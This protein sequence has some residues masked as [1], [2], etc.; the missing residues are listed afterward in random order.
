MG[1]WAR[2]AFISMYCKYSK[3]LP[4]LISSYNN[5]G[6]FAALYLSLTGSFGPVAVELAAGSVFSTALLSSDDEPLSSAAAI[7]SLFAFCFLFRALC[8]RMSF[9]RLSLA[10]HDLPAYK[11]CRDD[12]TANCAA[13]SCPDF[14]P[15]DN[16]IS[17]SYSP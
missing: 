16:V 6:L 17:Q 10:R 14:G 13:N 12:E 11:Q 4:F 7:A 15:Y 5:A 3:S 2:D 1:S 9:L 8:K